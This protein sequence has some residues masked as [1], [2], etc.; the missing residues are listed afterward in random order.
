[1]FDLTRPICNNPNNANCTDF[2]FCVLQWGT[3]YLTNQIGNV[4]YVRGLRDLNGSIPL[5][6]EVCGKNN[7]DRNSEIGINTARR[8]LNSSNGTVC[9]ASSLL[10]FTNS[11][12]FIDH[13]GNPYEIA[14]KLDLTTNQAALLSQY[15]SQT[16]NDLSLA[17]NSPTLSY[18]RARY[19]RDGLLKAMS[20]LRL[21][22]FDN[23][24]MKAFQQVYNDNRG[25]T[26][27]ADYFNNV[28]F[29]EISGDVRT[30]ICQDPVISLDKYEGIIYWM[31]AFYQNWQPETGAFNATKLI[32]DRLGISYAKTDAIQRLTDYPSIMNRTLTEIQNDFMNNFGCFAA[33]C[34][35][36]FLSERQYYD[37]SITDP[38]NIYPNLTKYPALAVRSVAQFSGNQAL[39]Q[40][41]IPEI[42]GFYDTHFGYLGK[43]FG[44][45]QDK[46]FSNNMGNRFGDTGS[47]TNYFQFFLLYQFSKYN[48]TSDIAHAFNIWS[49]ASYFSAYGD[50]LLFE[51]YLDGV[52]GQQSLAD[53]YQGYTDP[54]LTNLVGV[55]V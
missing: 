20:V 26:R 27:C 42:C 50:H 3:K 41:K 11:N 47:I 24:T 36:K 5:D 35:R 14:K 16:L 44:G 25:T 2:D 17:S 34:D 29:G 45:E 32:L 23:I 55:F 1:M 15:Y 48:R 22:V 51:W 12:F 53:L 31:I 33:P 39:L 18:F 52:I 9:S 46:V 40:N 4:Q 10:N 28:Q 6:Y 54:T 30:R 19:S 38:R 13:L 8:L 43:I 21:F 49:P 7:C 37:S